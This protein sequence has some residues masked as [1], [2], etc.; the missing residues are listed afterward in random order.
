MTFV[1]IPADQDELPNFVLHRKLINRIQYIWPIESRDDVSTAHFL[2]L[3]PAPNLSSSVI[4]LIGPRRG[5]G[6]SW[7]ADSVDGVVPSYK[8]HQQVVVYR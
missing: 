3:P 7:E 8:L 6:E 4:L 5:E 1:T 2:L